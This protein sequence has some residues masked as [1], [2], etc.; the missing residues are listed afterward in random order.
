MGSIGKPL[1]GG[2]CP[3]HRKSRNRVGDAVVDILHSPGL[4]WVSFRFYRSQAV[5]TGTQQRRL[6][7][8]KIDSSGL[9]T[10]AAV[11]VGQ[12]ENRF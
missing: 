9:R 3:Y 11:L 2:A 12:T 7:S 1:C 8:A 4:G 6:M 10:I 5:I